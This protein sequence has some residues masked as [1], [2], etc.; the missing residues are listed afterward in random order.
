MAKTK[1]VFIF[2]GVLL[3]LFGIF[4]VVVYLGSRNE[5]DQIANLPVIPV[6]FDTITS[7]DGDKV[8]LAGR[9][10]LGNSVNCEYRETCAD[11]SDKAIVCPISFGP[12]GD[13]ADF[14]DRHLNV[15]LEIPGTSMTEKEPNS[16][17]LPDFFDRDEFRLF[18]D[19]G[20]E[21]TLDDP[22]RVVGIISYVE[23]SGGATYVYLCVTRIEGGN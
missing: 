19:A 13:L 2:L 22:V 12:V 11:S 8:S 15:F 16:Y 4:V 6:T 23:E 21:L 9:V 3:L 14:Y 5:Q 10:L 1:Y 17:Y 18:T 20:Q 7:H